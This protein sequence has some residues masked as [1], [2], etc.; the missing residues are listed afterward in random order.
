MHLIATFRFLPNI[1]PKRGLPLSTGASC[2]KKQA[3][4]IWPIK[5]SALCYV[6][7]RLPGLTLFRM[8]QKLWLTSALFN[9]I[10]KQFPMA[11]GE[12][13]KLK[14]LNWTCACVSSLHSPNKTKK[15]VQ[16]LSVCCPRMSRKPRTAVSLCQCMCLAVSA[17][18][19][20]N[21][22]AENSE[23]VN[24]ADDMKFWRRRNFY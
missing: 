20:P 22:L 7:V 18:S 21:W 17:P 6:N 10:F 2:E 3:V 16:I 9:W 24:F 8:E 12:D 15:I 13:F 5:N 11:S 1:P 23:T 19:Q 14:V 4:E